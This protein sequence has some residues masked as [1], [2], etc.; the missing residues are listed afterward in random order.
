MALPLPVGTTGARV[1]PA[2]VAAYAIAV[3][4][5]SPSHGELGAGKN[6]ALGSDQARRAHLARRRC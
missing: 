4:G 6:C 5:L 1:A 2:P 3:V